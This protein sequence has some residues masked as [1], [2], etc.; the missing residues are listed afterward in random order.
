MELSCRSCHGMERHWRKCPELQACD[1]CLPM[2]CEFSFWSEWSPVGGCSG[3]C[4]R[5]RHPGHNNEC[6]NPCSGHTK[7]SVA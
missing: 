1:E 3:L 7:E 4:Q 2:D 5:Q 6:G